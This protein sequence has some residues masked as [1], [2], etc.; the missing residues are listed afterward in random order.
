M[1]TPRRVSGQLECTQGPARPLGIGERL[2]LAHGD[3]IRIQQDVTDTGVRAFLFPPQQVQTLFRPNFQLRITGPSHFHREDAV[4]QHF[5][6]HADVSQL[7]SPVQIRPYQER[8]AAGCGLEVH[9][10]L[11]RCITND[12]STAPFPRCPGGHR[13]GLGR[14][15][16]GTQNDHGGNQSPENDP[17][18]IFSHLSSTLIRSFSEFLAV[19]LSSVSLCPHSDA[20]KTR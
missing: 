15:S 11:H 3:S 12:P 9:R 13:L 1:E 7:E 20:A 6:I 10:L 17:A 8:P 14:R 19:V 4:Q 5:S 18:H 16:H 2:G